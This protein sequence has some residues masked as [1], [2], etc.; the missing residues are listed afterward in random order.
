MLIRSRQTVGNVTLLL[1][2]P[3]NGLTNQFV[4][5]ESQKWRRNRSLQQWSLRCIASL[6][7]T[8]AWYASGSRGTSGDTILRHVLE[9]RRHAVAIGVAGRRLADIR[10]LVVHFLQFG[11]N[12]RAVPTDGSADLV[13]S[14]S[15]IGF[16]HRYKV[17]AMSSALRQRSSNAIKIGQRHPM[18]NES[19]G[20][21]DTIQLSNADM[22][23]TLGCRSNGFQSS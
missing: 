1:S 15:E 5:A 23:H 13:G 10:N 2:R 9:R 18:D 17:Y 20:R 8:A 7:L 3:K 22:I 11:V 6:R 4:T 14:V 21:A 12:N 19:S 16:H